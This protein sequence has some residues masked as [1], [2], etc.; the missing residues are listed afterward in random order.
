MRVKGVKPPVEGSGAV[1]L[2]VKTLKNIE[3]R[4]E[5]TDSGCKS[6]Q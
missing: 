5:S 1:K 4:P 6:F 3:F 2:T